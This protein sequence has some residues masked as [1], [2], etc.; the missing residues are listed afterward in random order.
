MF[1]NTHL[2]YL[3]LKTLFHY[4]CSNRENLRI[5]V[6]IG[7]HYERSHDRNDLEGHARGFQGLLA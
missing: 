7:L 2:R 3:D 6:A 5:D 4:Q 1:E